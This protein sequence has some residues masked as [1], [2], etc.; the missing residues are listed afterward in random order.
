MAVGVSGVV[1]GA[2]GVV[3]GVVAG[4]TV[5]SGDVVVVG[6]DSALGAGLSRESRAFEVDISFT[7]G[8]G[9]APG[10]GAA[11]GAAAGDGAGV[12]ASAPGAGICV[13]GIAVGDWLNCPAAG[14]VAGI[15]VGAWVGIAGIAGIVGMGGM[16]GIAGIP[17]AMRPGGA[18]GRMPGGGAWLNLLPV[19]SLR[20]ITKVSPIAKMISRIGMAMYQSIVDSSSCCQRIASFG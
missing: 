7:S 20:R 5:V 1:T 13:A 6:V 15:T 18:A 2:V 16:G 11:T 8:A 3:A 9:A 12:G 17:V 4:V 10:A 19:S 14:V